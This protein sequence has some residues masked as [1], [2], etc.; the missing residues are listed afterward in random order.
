MGGSP[1][2]NE[3]GGDLWQMGWGGGGMDGGA[4]G[5]WPN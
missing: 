3:G 4:I 5:E 1:S 2:I